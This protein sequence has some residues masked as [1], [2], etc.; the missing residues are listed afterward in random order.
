[1]KISINRFELLDWMS[2]AAGGSHLRQYIWGRAID[3]FYSKLD[4][5][6]REA[7]FM[8]AKRDLT[9][10]YIPRKVKW[11]KDLYVPCGSR[12]FFQFLACYNPNNRFLVH[13]KGDIEGESQEK[14]V[15]AFKFE[16]E[17]YIGTRIMCSKPFI[18][19]K[20]RVGGLK[21]CNTPCIWHDKCARYDKNTEEWLNQY[22]CSRCD[23][24]INK[25]T[26]H[27]ADF[28]HFNI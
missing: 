28:E 3:E 8:Y 19:K 5:S 17:Y 10:K 7:V 1:M 21:K 15:K 24:F 26:N 22:V 25:K 16:D 4:E 27:G 18:K 14:T 23:W 6:E 2:G 9:D 20:W 12:E 11:Q 13:C